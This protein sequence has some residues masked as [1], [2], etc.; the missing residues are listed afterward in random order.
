MSVANR[1]N[2]EREERRA[3]IVEA[4]RAVFLRKGFAAATMDEVAAEA[5]VSKGTVYLYFESKD[6]L[7]VAM[8]SAVLEEV[9]AAFE[10]IG[11][12]DRPAVEAL[13]EMLRA[14]GDIA[15]EN[16]DEFRVAV[17]WMTSTDSVNTDTPSFRAHREAIDGLLEHLVAAIE[18]GKQD[19]SID[20][21]HDSFLL[22]GR[23]WA[24]VVGALL[25]RINSEELVK[26]Y[27]HPVDLDGFV[28]GFIDLLCEGLRTRK[29][30][31]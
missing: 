6:A 28:D 19:G 26:R 9:R 22:A 21:N 27:P 8:S 3:A 25:F 17:G 31:A 14:Y 7:F 29:I 10:R 16:G 11:A 13:R 23:I 24:G 30:P 4:A 5:E 12:E 15:A 18:R 1:R 20:S 2:R